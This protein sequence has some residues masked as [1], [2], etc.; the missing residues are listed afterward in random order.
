MKDAGLRIVLR[1]GI[2]R[3]GESRLLLL[4]VVAV[5]KD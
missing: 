4:S 5:G 3:V 1:G 2:Y